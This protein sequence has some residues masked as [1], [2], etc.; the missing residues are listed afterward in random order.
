MAENT[1]PHINPNPTG[2][3]LGAYK[4]AAKKCGCS[5]EDWIKRRMNGE[6]WCSQCRAWKRK[7]LFAIDRTRG[8]GQSMRCK[9]C[10][11]H[12]TKASKYGMTSD[13]LTAWRALHGEQCG[14]CGSNDLLNID[15]NHKTGKVRGLLCPNCNSA[16]GKLKESPALFASAIA[17]LEKNNG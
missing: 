10:V 5:V 4:S 2:R 14:I 12:A 9:S 7:E 13:E 6:K 15:H 1:N 16:I 11:S 17:Y 3:Q 8:C